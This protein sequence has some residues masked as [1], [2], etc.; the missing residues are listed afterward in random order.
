MA[1]DH[2]CQKAYK[3][4]SQW[5]TLS[6]SQPSIQTTSAPHATRRSWNVNMEQHKHLKPESWSQSSLEQEAINE[7]LA[8]AMKKPSRPWFIIAAWVGVFITVLAAGWAI[9]WEIVSAG[10]SGAFMLNR[11][12][13]EVRYLQGN[14]W[15]EVE[16]LKK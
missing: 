9:R 16:K 4:S 11:W 1:V 14:A 8:E 13:G 12:T 2:L 3:L 10:P 5:R 7:A 15:L 6:C